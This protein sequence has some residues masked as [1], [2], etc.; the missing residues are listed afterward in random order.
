MKMADY[1]VDITKNDGYSTYR[2]TIK[3]SDGKEVF[4]LPHINMD[5]FVSLVQY[6]DFLSSSVDIGYPENIVVEMKA[7]VNVDDGYEV[8]YDFNIGMDNRSEII[9]VTVKYDVLKNQYTERE[10]H[11]EEI[12]IPSFYLKKEN[13]NMIVKEE[14]NDD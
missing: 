6:F 9:R 2:I 8:Q 13:I 3:T 14:E 11:E 12:F 4:V 7:T 5:F 10:S 1:D